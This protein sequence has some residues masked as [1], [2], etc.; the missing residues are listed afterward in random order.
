MSLLLGAFKSGWDEV[1]DLEC[2]QDI[3]MCVAHQIA[4][5]MIVLDWQDFRDI[6]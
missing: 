4:K 5:A 2:S 1:T 6:A 3:F